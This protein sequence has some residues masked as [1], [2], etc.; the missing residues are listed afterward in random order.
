MAVVLSFN[1]DTLITNILCIFAFVMLKA[2]EIFTLEESF[3]SFLS[4]PHYNWD[5]RFQNLNDS[6]TGNVVSKDP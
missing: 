1:I 2:L 6:L 4:P 3:Q 5:A